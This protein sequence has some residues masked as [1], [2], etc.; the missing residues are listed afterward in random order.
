MKKQTKEKLG[1]QI[2]LLVVLVF[3]GQVS[4]S[5]FFQECSVALEKP[6][7]AALKKYLD[8]NQKLP[9]PN[10]CFR[11]NNK[12]FL[13]TVTDT[14]RVGQGLYYYDA[15]TNSFGLDGGRYSLVSVDREFAGLNNKRY[16]LLSFSNLSRG[17][18]SQDYTILNLVPTKDRKSYIHYSLLSWIE[19]PVS[20]LCGTRISTGKA[21]SIKTPQITNEGTESVQIIFQVTEQDCVTSEQ[22]TYS[23]VFALR[24]GVF[25]E[26]QN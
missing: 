12:Q 22:T 13:L 23:K 18:W 16:V 17:R 20:G 15:M 2:I 10:Q 11:L 3:S 5:Q 25:R 4:A 1:W 8:T 26:V 14:N 24:D 21:R 9:R 19:D 6:E 7:F